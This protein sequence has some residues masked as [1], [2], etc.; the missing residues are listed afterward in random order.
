MY[1]DN[2]IE[3][4]IIILKNLRQCQQSLFGI[5]SYLGIECKHMKIICVPGAYVAGAKESPIR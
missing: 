5:C 4:W 2:N 1:V 3:K